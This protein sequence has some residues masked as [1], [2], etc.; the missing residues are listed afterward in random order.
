MEKAGT[1]RS[2][3][4]HGLLASRSVQ[5]FG[6][7]VHTPVQDNIRGADDILLFFKHVHLKMM[8]TPYAH[9]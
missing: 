3:I 7:F 4:N 5:D 9:W 8:A 6:Y 2:M 1:H